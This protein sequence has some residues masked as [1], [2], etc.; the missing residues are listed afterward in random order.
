MAEVSRYGIVSSTLCQ[1]GDARLAEWRSSRKP[2]FCLPRALVPR[3]GRRSFGSLVIGANRG[4]IPDVVQDEVNGLLFR[5]GKRGIGRSCSPSV[6]EP[7]LCARLRMEARKQAE[8]WSWAEATHSLRG[9]YRTAM[10]PPRR[11]KSA[12]ESSFYMQAVRKAAIG[13]IKVLLR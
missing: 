12:L 5:R 10:A 11:Q 7:E 8:N 1:R 3:E 9:F 13:E 4:G 2:P 6:A